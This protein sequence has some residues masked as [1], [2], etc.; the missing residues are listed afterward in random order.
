MKTS[1]Y[2]H[3]KMVAQNNKKYLAQSTESQPGSTFN[4]KVR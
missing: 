2:W 4:G 1:A 3:L